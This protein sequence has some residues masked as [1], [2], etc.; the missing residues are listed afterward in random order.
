MQ[1]RIA[2]GFHPLW[3]RAGAPAKLRVVRTSDIVRLAPCHPIGNH[4]GG[5]CALVGAFKR[6][7][8]FIIFKWLLYMK[9]T[10]W[11]HVVKYNWK[12]YAS[13]D[14]R[15]GWLSSISSKGRGNE[16]LTTHCPCNTTTLPRKWTYAPSKRIARDPFPKRNECYIE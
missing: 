16:C 12:Y 14:Q 5:L 15:R 10:T 3:Q 8:S 1:P 13:V 6:I 2:R 9:W 7:Y 11:R 4:C